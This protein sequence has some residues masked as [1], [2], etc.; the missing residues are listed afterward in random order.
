MFLREPLSVRTC[1]CVGVYVFVSSCGS[2][3]GSAKVDTGE[4]GGVGRTGV[5]VSYVN[6]HMCARSLLSEGP[7]RPDVVTGLTLGRN[8]RLG[9][10]GRDGSL[11]RG[12]SPRVPPQLLESKYLL[13]EILHCFSPSLLLCL[14]LVRTFTLTQE[15]RTNP[16]GRVRKEVVSEERRECRR[17]PENEVR[18][19]EGDGG[20]G[21]NRGIWSGKIR[22]T[23]SDLHSRN[24]IRGRQTSKDDFPDVL[25]ISHVN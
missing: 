5:R 16:W 20:P 21:V 14:C 2:K 19:K 6:G 23:E 15:V 7:F 25:N 22:I 13:K 11:R 4:D 1:V 3:G 10:G 17:V 18:Q 9:E 24:V 8:G 12:P